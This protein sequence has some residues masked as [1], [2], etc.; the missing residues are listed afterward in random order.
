MTPPLFNH[1][2]LEG[3][4]KKKCICSSVECLA[5]EAS[6]RFPLFYFLPVKK[7]TWWQ[8]SVC[9]GRMQ[10]AWSTEVSG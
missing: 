9:L 2:H 4:K 7:N 10:R 1:S 8:G 5:R 6:F 3:K